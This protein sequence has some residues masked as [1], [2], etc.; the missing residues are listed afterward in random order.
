MFTEEEIEAIVRRIVAQICPEKVIVFGSYAKGT[1]TIRSDLDLFI[2]QNTELPMALRAAQV[3]PW[4]A[5]SLIPIDVHIYTREEVEA[6]QQEEFSF[7]KSV[8]KTGRVVYE[9]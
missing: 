6:Y 5:H 9:G 2:I 7:V 1:A 4:I 8:L 3:K